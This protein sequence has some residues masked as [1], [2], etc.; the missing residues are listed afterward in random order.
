MSEAPNVPQRP[1]WLRWWVVLLAGL[2]GALVAGIL[3]LYSIRAAG[4]AQLRAQLDAWSAAGLPTTWEQVL[5]DVPAADPEL[6][7]RWLAL[8]RRLSSIEEPANLHTELIRSWPA[9]PDLGILER[10]HPVATFTAA[11]ELTA[12]AD[13]QLA[14]GLPALSVF[15]FIDR[16]TV[17]GQVTNEHFKRL[18]ELFSDHFF[19]LNLGHLRFLSVLPTH[20]LP[21]QDLPAAIAQ[22]RVLREALRPGSVEFYN[23]NTETLA[24]WHVRLV[25]HAYAAGSVAVGPALEA[26]L[27]PG[28]WSDQLRQW[29]NGCSLYVAWSRDFCERDERKVLRYLE[30]RPP[31]FPRKARNI[32]PFLR[33]QYRWH[34][35]QAAGLAQLLSQV[36]HRCAEIDDLLAG[37]PGGLTL[38]PPLHEAPEWMVA[39][40]SWSLEKWEP[41]P[42]ATSFRLRSAALAIRAVECWRQTGALPADH[43]ALLALGAVEAA[44]PHV[45]DG[46]LLYERL[47]PLAFRIIPDLGGAS[48]WPRHVTVPPRPVGGAGSTRFDAFLVEVDLTT[49]EQQRKR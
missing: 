20:G 43:A 23:P 6:A 42:Y 30:I 9:P 33:E 27:E 35:R 1:W 15:S 37:R 31:V 24:A 28:L 48:P 16:E 22:G 5:A 11:R 40:K 38:L 18:D 25:L 49:A 32:L 8:C 19:V 3:S 46:A 17:N 45:L 7:R 12:E 21:A 41:A 4:R 39:V 26:L 34:F 44:P 29:R 14:A 2:A 36:Q 47:G 10:E 13:A